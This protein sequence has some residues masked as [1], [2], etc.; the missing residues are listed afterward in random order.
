MLRTGENVFL[1]DITGDMV[2]Q[3]LSIDLVP[4]ESSGSAFLN[5]VLNKDYKMGRSNENFVYIKA[6]E[7]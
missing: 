6:Y 7:E 3:E 2:E 5:S 4:I 1:D